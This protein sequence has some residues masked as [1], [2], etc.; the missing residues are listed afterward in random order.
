MSNLVRLEQ[1]P[2]NG[3]RD[4]QEQDVIGQ[5]F[6]VIQDWDSR[7]KYEYCKFGGKEEI[8]INLRAKF[9]FRLLIRRI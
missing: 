7:E 4:L 5:D 6:I 2:M 1:A 8:G 3:I 9:R